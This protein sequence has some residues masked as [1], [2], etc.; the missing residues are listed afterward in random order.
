MIQLYDELLARLGV[1]NYRLLLNSIGDATC[2]PAYVERL[3]AWLDEHDD[4]LDE[5]ARQKRATNPLRVF[6]VKNRSVLEALADAPKIGDALCDEC[7]AHFEAVQAYLE[8]QASRSRSRRRSSAGSTTTRARPSSSW[9]RRS[10]RR[11]RS[12]AAAATTA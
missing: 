8:D 12:P 1:T 10:A 4:V 6:D 5:D 11:A 3:T 9:T 2:R 7:R